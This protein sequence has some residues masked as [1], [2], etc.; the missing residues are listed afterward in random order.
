LSDELHANRPYDQLVSNLISATGL[1][2]DRPQV[3][4]ITR[5][6]NQN[7]EPNDPDP[8]LLA[9]RTSRAF[10]GLRIDCLQCHDDF[11]GNVSVGALD[12]PR[13]GTQRDFHSMAAFFSQAEN[14]LTG[15]RDNV[16]AASY[17][18]KLLGAEAEE[19]IEP[20]VPIL[21]E[22]LDEEIVPLRKRL[23][24]WLTHSENRIFARATANRVWAIL[25]GRGLV[26]P[27]DDIPIDQPAPAALEF[28]ADDF[29][30]HQFDLQRLIRLIAMSRPFTIESVVHFQVTQAHEDLLAVFPLTRLRPE[31]MAGAMLQATRLKTIDAS[32]HILTQLTRFGQ[33]RDFVTRFGDLGEDEFQDRGE[34]VTQRL[35]LFNGDLM[36]ENLENGLNVPVRLDRLTSD[37]KS[38]LEIV[39]LST[40]SRRP[41]DAEL[42]KFRPTENGEIPMSLQILDLYWSI[43]NSA[44]FRWNH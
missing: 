4:F 34:T 37:W 17:R 2:T 24:A 41:T 28:L 36:T 11:L 23:A 6:I 43:I 12:Q 20:R 14:S 8:M 38:T 25:F 32:S 33:Q 30:R 3:N 1:W 39:F 18:T 13:T 22:L 42:E 31:Q 19:A 7:M 35:L 21:P 26:H 16:S 9:G 29:I 10:L 44:E 27:V 40:L 5:T 15:I